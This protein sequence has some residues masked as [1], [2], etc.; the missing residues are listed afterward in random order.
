M[1]FR[2]GSLVAASAA[3][4]LASTPA[5]AAK[6]TFRYQ[7][8]IGGVSNVSVS[9][10]FDNWDPKAHPMK[11]DD[12]DGVWETVIELPAGRIEYKFVVNGTWMTDENAAEFVSDPYGGRNSV[13]V[14]ADQPL[15]IG[16][17]STIQKP[18]RGGSQG[19]RKVTFQ[20]KPGGKPNSVDLC[21]TF[22][23]WTVGRTPMKD[24]DGDGVY[25][26]TLLLPANEYQY[27]FVVDGSRWIQDSEKQ[28]SQKDDG[29]G[30][31]NSIL[32][33]D[34]RF[35]K[36]EVKAGDGEVF[37][38]GVTHEQQATEVNTL[39]GGRVQL[40]A[41]AH[42]GDVE[43]IEIVTFANGRETATPMIR[44]SEDQVYDY[45]RGELA[46]P[47]GETPYLFRYRDGGKSF[48]LTSAGMAPT[49]DRNRWTYSAER[50]P[51]FVTPQWVKDAVIYQIFP[52]RFCNGSKAN[53]PNFSEWYYE[54][55]KTLPAGGRI[56]PGHQEYY[57]LVPWNDVG[58]LT[59]A[60]HTPD[61]R[62]WMGFYGGDI[63]GVRQKLGYLKDLG[64]TA[65]YFN[66]LFQAKS[67]HK[68]DC[69]DYGKI[70]PHFGTNDEFIAFV[71]EAKA[72]G[73]RIVLDIVYNH[74]GDAHWAFKDAV[75]K[76][77]ASPYYSWFEFKQWPLPAGWPN[78]GRAWKAS[79]YYYCW[80]GF[81]SLPDLNFDL[82]RNNDAEKS[83]K[84]V[85]EA[86]PNVAL[87]KHLLDTT[88]Y[89]L[90]TADADGLRLDV[91]NE[92]PFWFWKLF[93][94]RVKRVKPDAWIVGE[95]WGRATD[96]VKPGVYDAVMNYAFFRD[97]VT[98]FLGLGQGG[99]AE[100][101]A[102]L[103]NGRFAYPTQAVEV[104]M[105]LIDS[106]DTPRF[107]TQV[108][109]NVNRLKL[110]AM[111]AMTY[112]GAPTIYYGDEIGTLG[113]PDPDCR[114]PFDWD[115]TK[116]PA[117]VA[118]LEYYKKLTKARHASPAL[119]TG[120]FRTLYAV[121][122]HYAY[123]RSGGGEDYVVMLNGDKSE[124]QLPIDLAA[125]G[126]KVKARDVLSGAEESWSGK[127]TVKVPGETGRLFKI[128]ADGN[129]AK[130]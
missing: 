2:L 48:Y 112:V 75:E 117:K 100:F 36:V 17:G 1:S 60:P 24:A 84:D 47:A 85:K 30:G 32:R 124:V 38:D 102:A 126:G 71:K 45:F 6:I 59:N 94:E 92:V 46:M 83:I 73:I 51:E 111:F 93:N 77:P 108:S 89:W 27:K 116:D 16:H 39:G 88:E 106:H 55:K 19:L 25:T 37:G 129:A 97:P 98:R 8:V 50:F 109:G 10:S 122:N 127:A 69:A 86:Q 66:P 67:T 23:D 80:W 35:P 34:D 78:V 110:A 4:L 79:D 68:Y 65:I 33:V 70:D 52:D 101:D 61:K 74:C 21:G 3:L 91:P 54:G 41:R 130:N 72:Q 13:A 7:P 64:V 28:D 31:Q 26:A 49:S 18:A 22:N 121:G 115:Y 125:W 44:F 96:W 87:I 58:A 63:E 53:D 82:S 114:R 20:Y 11:D 12:K 81:G 76:G 103:A 43:A 118:L 56:D 14:I 29:H 90:K 119:R 104:Q 120:S 123:A 95:L 99:A 113:G 40:T 15:V 57:H 62:D 42:H 128:S 107:L 5:W 105:N 9:G